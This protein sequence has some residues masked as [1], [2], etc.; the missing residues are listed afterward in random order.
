MKNR[1]RS[2][3]RGR[4]GECL[5]NRANRS[6]QRSGEPRVLARKPAKRSRDP[7]A[8]AVLGRRFADRAS[9]VLVRDRKPPVTFLDCGGQAP[10]LLILSQQPAIALLG[11]LDQPAQILLRGGE[12]AV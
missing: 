11:F 1:P 12:K 4:S 5:A 10:Q 9:E 3:S 2:A 7:P 8:R 6:A